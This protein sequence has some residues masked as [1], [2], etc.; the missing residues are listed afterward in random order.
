MK[1]LI[2]YYGGKQRLSSKIVPY[3]EAIPHTVRVI[4]FAGG[5]GV[6]SNWERPKVS[7][8]N[9][10]RVVIND[11]DEDIITLY[12]VARDKPNE[13]QRLLELTP[14]S[15]ADHARSIAILRDK[16]WGSDLDRAWAVFVNL[17]C[18]F[19]NQK[20]RGWR[21]QVKSRNSAATWQ[22]RI[23]R[24]GEVLPHFEDVHIGC[25]DALRFIERWDS[26]QSL[27]YLDPPYPGANQGHYGGYTIED[28]SRLCDLLDSIDG[29]YVMSCYPQIIQ[30]KSAQR[31]IDFST[32][33]SASGK[34]QVGKGRDKT[35]AA[36]SEEL[37]NRKRT[38]SIWVC[39]RSHKIR[40]DLVQIAIR[41]APRY[42]PN[43]V[44]LV[45]SE[46]SSPTPE[47]MTTSTLEPATTAPKIDPQTIDLSQFPSASQ[48]SLKSWIDTI[49][50]T[51][52]NPHH[53]KIVEFFKT[54]CPK[55]TDVLFSLKARNIHNLTPL[56]G[57]SKLGDRGF[58]PCSEN[59]L[60]MVMVFDA[61]A[62]RAQEGSPYKPFLAFVWGDGC[63]WAW[64]PE[65]Q[66]VPWIIPFPPKRI[67]I[68]Q[69]STAYDTRLFSCEYDQENFLAPNTIHVDTFCLATMV[70]G[71]SNQ[72]KTAYEQQQSQI[73][74][75]KG[76]KEWVSRAS[77]RDLASLCKFFC[78]IEISK[79]VRKDGI[80]TKFE[81]DFN[82][83]RLP[84]DVIEYCAQ[85]VWAT[86]HL[87]QVLFARVDNDFFTS[88]V[89]WWGV[90]ELSQ[91]RFHLKDYDAFLEQSEKDYQVVKTKNAEFIKAI[92]TKELLRGDQLIR[93]FIDAYLE[94]FEAERDAV[95]S[96]AEALDADSFPSNVMPEYAFEDF[97]KRL[98]FLQPTQ[99]GL[100]T[101]GNLNF[102]VNKIKYGTG[103]ATALKAGGSKLKTK[104]IK[105]LSGL[106]ERDRKALVK[107][108]FSVV[109]PPLK[110]SPLDWSR[111]TTGDNKGQI[112]W[113][114]ALSKNDYEINRDA[115]VLLQLEWKY[116]PIYWEPI[117]T[118]KGTAGTW[119][120]DSERL[121]HPGGPGKNLDSPLCKDYL[122]HAASGD[123]KSKIIS[124]ERLIE[125]FED[126]NSIAQW[127]SFRK[128]L[129][130][131]Y[132][133]PVEGS[134]NLVLTTSDIVP[135]G[136]VTRRV[137][138]P[139]WQVSPKP[140]EKI[141]SGLMRH[142]SVPDG[143]SIVGTDFDQ[144][145]SWMATVLTDAKAGKIGSNP[146][147]QAVL[148]GD[149]DKGTDDHSL[150]A[151]QLG[152]AR[153]HAKT[154]NFASAYLAG[155]SK[156]AV[157]LS[158]Q[159]EQP[160]KETLIIAANFLYY[161]QGDRQVYKQLDKQ[162]RKAGCSLSE[163][164]GVTNGAFESFSG[165]A[166]VQKTTFETLAGYAGTPNI[167]TAL[168]GVKIPDSLNAAFVKD[169]F[170]TTRNNWQ[171]QSPCVDVLH[172]LLTIVRAFCMEYGV[173]YWFIYAVHD[174]VFFALRQGQE[175][176]FEAILQ[177][178]HQLV[179]Q[180][181]YEQALK[182]A[183]SLKM[184][185]QQISGE[186]F[187]CPESQFWFSEINV[188]QTV[189][190]VI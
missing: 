66:Q 186:G 120:T 126:L 125:L 108:L 65:S 135:I 75:G 5:L 64:L 53:K 178:A 163:A 98:G 185:G 167:R 117:K 161:K 176:L 137:T 67:V 154:L 6:E 150:T 30:P 40:P 112:R 32:T 132:R 123:L 131:V 145:E 152:I 16:S 97:L 81:K 73:K 173:E 45:E 188:G 44:A 23:K 57:W 90:Q 22:N 87:A 179:K 58:E 184:P 134:D 146:W 11:L 110:D 78:G 20:N 102:T 61:E 169:E 101:K 31:Q 83:H 9:L 175:P 155:L 4:P 151:K 187:E 170:F 38:D 94:A 71:L 149:K 165:A 68:G 121:P 56:P 12:R 111:L 39:D 48:P 43:S 158:L 181:T 105:F 63:Y 168:L 114:A 177:R 82:F 7:N 93:A 52:W 1:P 18:S 113:A 33:C 133:L 174:S 109:P 142:V 19:S 84:T 79:A 89:S 96:E 70:C 140:S 17:N 128:R 180:L 116:E 76:A 104:L 127:T 107:Q 74:S 8:N 190:E 13:L 157:S 29:S 124:K 62:V 25:E 162:L 60:P 144:E 136:T 92:A 41:N 86:F 171:I 28:F 156:L 69:N 189:A 27:F 36:T 115:I 85:D 99:M 3:L 153:K 49:G 77:P 88:P 103:W 2:S 10:Y 59:D 72:Q 130:A 119:R 143:F 55:Y 42:Q 54:P 147:C 164:W 14:Y 15:Q 159:L 37:G 166:G 51:L 35:R 26:P 129:G 46:P 34:G 106:L 172:C 91:S 160:L 183:N 138:S 80:E 100:A 21:T 50:R 24:L 148:D 95:L 47:P 139:V 122:V 141:G 182:H 118:E